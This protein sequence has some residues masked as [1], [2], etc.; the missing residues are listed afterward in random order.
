MESAERACS[1]AFLP[2]DDKNVVAPYRKRNPAVRSHDL[3]VVDANGKRENRCFPDSP[4][5]PFASRRDSEVA[6]P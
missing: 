3:I 6:T 2:P 1:W 5:E 4:H